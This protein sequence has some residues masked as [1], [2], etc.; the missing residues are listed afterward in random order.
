[1]T[2]KQQAVH[3]A[4]SNR[5]SGQVGRVVKTCP[6]N[7]PFKFWH[8]NMAREAGR[9][10]GPT[11]PLRGHA[12]PQ[13]QR[14][15]KQ[16]LRA[17]VGKEWHIKTMMGE[18]RDATQQAPVV[19]ASSNNILSLKGVRGGLNLQKLRAADVLGCVCCSEGGRKDPQQVLCPGAC[20]VQ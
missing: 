3:V 15:R 6:A 9:T 14:A 2:E 10:P 1:M 17:E 18:H 13:T 16:R 19:L 12:K 20:T 7:S 4:E 11:L 8:C 5:N